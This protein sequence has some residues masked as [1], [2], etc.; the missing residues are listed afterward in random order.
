MNRVLVLLAT[1]LIGSTVFAQTPDCP[2]GTTK[3]NHKR[4]AVKNR[5]IP[6][7]IHAARSVQMGEMVD[8]WD[9][10]P[11]N[12]SGTY[13]REDTVFTIHG[14][15]RLIKIE[16]NDCDIHM[17]IAGTKTGNSDRII[18][19]IPNT[20][21]FCQLRDKLVGILKTNFGVKKVGKTKKEFK[22]KV[23]EI[24]L[25]G[26]A[27]CDTPHRRKNNPTNKKG[28]GHGSKNVATLWE[29]HPVL[30]LSIP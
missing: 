11:K 30:K 18:A 26:Y 15:L 22:S 25:T 20:T 24:T 13:S 19:E 3:A 10:P 12:T 5:P 28:S 16:S 2:C 8:L 1:L 6:A 9:I 21:E 27:F 7:S 29:M 23:P 14:F 4:K 17:E